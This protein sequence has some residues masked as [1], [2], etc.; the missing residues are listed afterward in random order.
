MRATWYEIEKKVYVLIM[1]QCSWT[2]VW[3]RESEAAEVDISMN[4]LTS[5]ND[6]VAILG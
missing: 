6:L 3:E 4:H 1:N 5:N 2:E